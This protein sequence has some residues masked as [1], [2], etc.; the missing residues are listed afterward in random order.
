ME[1]PVDSKSVL[2]VEKEATSLTI[3]SFW[4]AALGRSAPQADCSGR[5]EAEQKSGGSEPKGSSSSSLIA[6]AVLLFSILVGW[7]I[8]RALVR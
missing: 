5:R 6:M 4:D 3:R 2:E 1:S 7:I 8:T